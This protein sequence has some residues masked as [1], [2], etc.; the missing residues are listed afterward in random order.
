VPVDLR[1]LLDPAHTAVVTMEVQ[2]GVL[3]DLSPMRELAD[4]AASRQVV[5]HAAT[6]V[7]AARVAGAHVVHCLAEHDDSSPR[8]SPLLRALAKRGANLPSGSDAAALVA[9]LGPEPGDAL[10]IRRHGL[11]PFPGTDLDALLRERDV[12]TVVAVG[13][14]LNVGVTG[15]VMVA[16]DLGYEVVVVT[17]AVVGLPVEYGDEVLTHTIPALATRAT[18]DEIVAVWAP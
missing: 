18:T 4:A 12:R 5:E 11:T 15:L 17:D 2:R 1:A 9:D 10:S 6:V 7:S 16:V 14:S 8:N 3:G 13:A